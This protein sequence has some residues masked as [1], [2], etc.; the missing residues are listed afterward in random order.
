MRWRRER[1]RVGVVGFGDPVGEGSVS[2]RS[3][4]CSESM[5]GI[6]AVRPQ[7][8]DAAVLHRVVVRHARL[9]RAAVGFGFGERVTGESEAALT[10]VRF[11]RHPADLG[12]SRLLPNSKA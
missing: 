11:T 4:G 12:T 9:R 6:L 1:S 10:G 7:A 3:S 5:S 2:V 8:V